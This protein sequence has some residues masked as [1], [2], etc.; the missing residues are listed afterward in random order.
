LMLAHEAK[1]HGCPYSKQLHFKMIYSKYMFSYVNPSYSRYQIWDM[2]SK[3][4]SSYVL[5][6]TKNKLSRSIQAT[7]YKN[8]ELSSSLTHNKGA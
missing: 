7:I 3:K 4:M 1:K 8:Q 5:H 6:N 2:F